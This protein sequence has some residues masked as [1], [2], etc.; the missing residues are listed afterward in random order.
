MRHAA[1]SMH[2]SHATCCRPR[3]RSAVHAKARLC[4]RTD[5]FHG[6]LSQRA[7][8]PL[9]RNWVANLSCSLC[10]CVVCI[11]KGGTTSTTA[12]KCKANKRSANE[13][14]GRQDC[15]IA[16]AAVG[17]Q[18]EAEAEAESGA[19]IGP[20]V[21]SLL[22]VAA[23]SRVMQFDAAQNRTN[24]HTHIVATHTHTPTHTPAHS[25]TCIP[26]SRRAALP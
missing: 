5:S 11:K 14:Q 26:L 9:T 16:G 19:G 18:A 13:D 25:H 3:R 7:A 23:F 15:R 10:L 6:R 17:A 2:M 20:P 1:C 24:A 22:L 8:L 4:L 12:S 21:S